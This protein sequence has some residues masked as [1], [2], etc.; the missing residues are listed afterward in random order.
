MQFK[1]TATFWDRLTPLN[2]ARTI[3]YPEDAV[4]AQAVDHLL[5]HTKSSHY[6]VKKMLGTRSGQI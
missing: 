6:F 3:H 4:L 1:S 5:N 2:H